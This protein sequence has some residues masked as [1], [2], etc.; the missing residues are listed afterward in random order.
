MAL[1]FI[2][3]QFQQGGTGH[4]SALGHGLNGK[5][6][7]VGHNNGCS[8]IITVRFDAVKVKFHQKLTFF[9]SLAVLDLQGAA[10][11]SGSSCSGSGDSGGSGLGG[12]ALGGDFVL[13]QDQG[14]NKG[15]HS[16]DHE[17][18][19]GIH[20]VLAVIR[21]NVH[22]HGSNAG[23]DGRKG[24]DLGQANEQAA[25]EA[26]NDNGRHDL[27]VLQGNAVQSRL[28]DAEQTEDTAQKFVAQQ[29]GVAVLA[30]ATGQDQ[31]FFHFYVSSKSLNSL[32]IISAN[33]LTGASA[34]SV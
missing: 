29:I 19:D 33:A 31:N 11:N 2:C 16:G 10:D 20:E 17:C 1:P 6:I 32:L 34:I 22:G 18:D 4:H 8:Y 14:Q 12:L 15:Q 24:L 30:G 23:A 25:D 28:G 21:I 13:V 26:G 3:L 7:G 9:H 27:L 5:L